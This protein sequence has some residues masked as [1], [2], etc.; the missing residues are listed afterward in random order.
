MVESGNE[1]RQQPAPQSPPRVLLAE[2]DREMRDMLAF[3]LRRAGYAV[4]TLGDGISL[5]HRL[6][7]LHDQEGRT[8]DL[9][10]SDIRM[11]GVTGL[12][13]LEYLQQR[14]HRPPILLMTAFG[15]DQTHRLAERFGAVAVVDK[16]FDLVTLMEKIK[17]L[18]PP[19]TCI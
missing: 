14:D 2:D 18:A 1:I 7:E 16:P 9:V 5:L 8:C 13:V 12:E 15:D 3:V 17:I 6:D 19:P 11:P 4:E 10:I